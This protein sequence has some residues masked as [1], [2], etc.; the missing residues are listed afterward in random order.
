MGSR[1][2][3]LVLSNQSPVPVNRGD[4]NRLFHILQLLTEIADVRLAFFERGWEATSNPRRHLEGALR[5]LETASL[6][7]GRAAVM[8]QVLWS[9]LT[10][11]PHIA[12]RFDNRASR[13]FVN[14]QAQETQADLIWAFQISMAPFLVGLGGRLVV[15]IVDSPSR[16]VYEVSHSGTLPWTSKLVAAMNWRISAFENQVAATAD[17]VLVNSE[18]DKVHLRRLSPHANVRILPNCVP[19]SLLERAWRPDHRKRRLLTVGH[20]DYPPYRAAMSHFIS[21]VFPLIR[22]R[23]ADVELIVVGS[24]SDRLAQVLAEQ[25]GVKVSGYVSDLYALYESAHALITPEGVV[26]GLQYKVAEAMA[27]GLPVVGSTSITRASPLVNREHVLVGA[28]DQEIAEAAIEVLTDIKLAKQISLSA[29][30]LVSRSFTWE[31]QRPLIHEI[32]AGSSV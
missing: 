19:T 8:R 6:P 29:K 27:V 4:R 15:D 3:V 2:R 11:K 18:P 32:I 24:G 5:G 12:Y 28:T 7:I 23:I 26:M 31:R 10:G 9:V 25:P 13:A 17:T 14:R 30:D 22:R 16:Y 1:P 21:I 20:F